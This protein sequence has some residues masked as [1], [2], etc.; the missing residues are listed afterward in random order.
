MLAAACLLAAIQS[1]N[2]GKNDAQILAMGSDGWADFYKEAT[3]NHS[4]SNQDHG[5]ALYDEA[6]ERRNEKLLAAPGMKDRDKRRRLIQLLGD[7]TDRIVSLHITLDPAMK[8]ERAPWAADE[9]DTIYAYLHPAG[10]K[11]AKP[12]VVSD[13]SKVLA[14]IPKAIEDQGADL[15]ADER[16]ELKLKLQDAV[17]FYREI[18]V[19]VSQTT[20]RAGSDQILGYCLDTAKLI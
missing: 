8:H 6:A 10:Q 18:V 9:L 4:M 7:Y 20:G 3:N 2:L 17:G 16:H 5:Y 14:K 12:V 11:R 13:V 15:E 19:L 1:R